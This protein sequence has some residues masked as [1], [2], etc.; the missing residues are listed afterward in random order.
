MHPGVVTQ[1]QHLFYNLL[2]N[3]KAQQP[4]VRAR[5]KTVTTCGHGRE[6]LTQQNKDVQLGRIGRKEGNES[7][8]GGKSESRSV[9][10]PSRPRARI[11]ME[12]IPSAD[13][14]RGPNL[15][16]TERLQSV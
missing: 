10:E 6:P 16:S 13:M 8:G 1:F 7:R 5:R 14:L 12:I 15:I 9:E 2:T 4:R 11:V 3:T